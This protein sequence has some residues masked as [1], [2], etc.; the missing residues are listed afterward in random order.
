ML[1]SVRKVLS[2]FSRS[3][4]T[5]LRKR[6]L[7]KKLRDP[8]SMTRREMKDMKEAMGVL[9]RELRKKGWIE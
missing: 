5:L 3:L 1:K 8:F 9:E 2:R 4:R 6:Q 7:K